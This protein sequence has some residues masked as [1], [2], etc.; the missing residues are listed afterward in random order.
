MNKQ[1][2]IKRRRIIELLS[3]GEF[4]SGEIIGQHLG[5]TRA[6]VS[7][8]IR[9]L[10]DLGLDIYSVTGRGYKLANDVQLLQPEKIKKYMSGDMSNQIDVLNIVTSTNDFIKQNI[11]RLNSGDVC[12]AEAQTA[13]RGRQ[14]REWVSPFGCNLYF[15]M[16][17]QFDQ[18]YKVLSGLS[19][20]VGIALC[21][22]LEKLGID[23]L[24]LKWPNDIYFNNRKLAGIL[25]EIEGQMDSACDCII[26]I[27]LN[28]AMPEDVDG[29]DQPWIDLKQITEK[30][31]DKNRL[32]GTLTE[33]L[34]SLIPIFEQEG[35]AS[36]LS[37]WARRDLFINKQ[38]DLTMGKKLISGYCRGIGENGE[39]LIEH[40][41]QLNSYHGGEIS[42]R[43]R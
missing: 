27:G 9:S 39:L 28:I 41:G 26:G 36:F 14:G 30:N 3:S 22:S 13:G 7:K 20:L 33:T 2:E 38:V 16:Y 24:A 42:V 25:V 37:Y 11:E 43:A 15:S 12:I 34:M 5:I 6:A 10:N 31:I 21:Q 29:I 1:V 19:L 4:Y 35:L 23:G 17:W 40:N 32:V 18:G 8:H